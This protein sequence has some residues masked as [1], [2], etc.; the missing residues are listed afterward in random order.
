MVKI[1][2][3]KSNIITTSGL[4]IDLFYIPRYVEKANGHSYWKDLELIERKHFKTVS[5]SWNPKYL[6]VSSLKHFN[7]FH[8]ISASFELGNDK[9]TDDTGGVLQI[10]SP[11]CYPFPRVLYAEIRCSSLGNNLWSVLDKLYFFQNIV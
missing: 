1:T 2:Q 4:L 6:Q 8:L 11:S 5:K 3:T 7:I 9:P 10:F